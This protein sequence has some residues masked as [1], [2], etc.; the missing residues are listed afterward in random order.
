MINAIKKW[1]FF[2]LL[3]VSSLL[4]FAQHGTL[5]VTVTNVTE[6]RG[7]IRV[8]LFDNEDDFLEKAAYGKVVAANGSSVVVRMERIPHGTYGVSVIHDENENGKLDTN[9]VGIPKEG[10]GFGNNAMGLFGPPSF[11]K[12][13]VTI[14]E[15]PAIQE[16]R[17][18]HF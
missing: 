10:F 1:V 5:E 2:A 17:L 16:L 8:G 13:S 4:A 14:G 15:S 7:T 3:S 9:A 12:A 6:A 18:K 11:E